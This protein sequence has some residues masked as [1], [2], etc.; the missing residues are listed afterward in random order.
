[1]AWAVLPRGNA[2]GG[3]IM[4]LENQRRSR[5]EAIVTSAAPQASAILACLGQA[6][7][8]WDLATDAM[9]WSDH[10]VSVFPDIGPE[11]LATGSEFAKLI[12]PAGSVRTDALAASGAAYRGEGVAYRIEYGVRASTSHPL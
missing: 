3:T 5:N 2:V 4:P 11:R 1:M 7:F 9:V 10:L 6:A 12:E 8:T